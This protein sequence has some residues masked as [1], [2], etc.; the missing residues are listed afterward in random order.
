LSSNHSSLE[1]IQESED[2]EEISPVDVSG[3][4]QSAPNSEHSVVVN[5]DMSSGPSSFEETHVLNRRQEDISD[6]TK[7]D[8]ISGLVPHLENR[9]FD[10]KKV[11]LVLKNKPIEVNQIELEEP[12]SE[13]SS[14]S[15]YLHEVKDR[16][17]LKHRK[18]SLS[19]KHK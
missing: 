4:S 12:E 7:E 6:G 18:E 19:C 17:R 15:K 1:V 5:I 2:Y 3:S 10:I 8:A 11:N 9:D 16:Y 13:S 14:S